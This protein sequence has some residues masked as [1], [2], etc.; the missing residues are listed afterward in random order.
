MKVSDIEIPYEGHRDARY[1]FFEIVPGAISWSILIVPFILSI[2]SP[3]LTIF[4]I[5]S[6]MLLWFVKSIAM[7]MR[8]IQGWQ[9]M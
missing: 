6:Y 4:F 2:V 7:N 5:I 9:T 8:A 1:R 3:P